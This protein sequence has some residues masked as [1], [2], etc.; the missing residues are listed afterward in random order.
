LVGVGSVCRRQST[1]DAGRI[2][3]ALHLAG[4]TRLHGFGFK[5][6]G[7]R[8]YGRL[9]A[10]ADSMAWSYTARRQPPLSGCVGHLNCA[11]CPRYAASWRTPVPDACAPARP[12]HLQPLMFTDPTRA[13]ACPHLPPPPRRPP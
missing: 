5:I 9:L 13:A 3:T 12:V 7:L 4:L 6:T 8:R 2:L 10:S 1:T 11:N